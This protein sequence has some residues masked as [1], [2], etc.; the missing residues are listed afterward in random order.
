MQTNLIFSSSKQRISAAVFLWQLTRSPLDALANLAR[1]QGDIARARIGKREIFLLNHPEFI[2]QALVKQSQ[3]FVKGLA[4]QRARLLLGE[5]LLTSEGEDHLAQRRA[6]QPAF[7]PKRIDAYLPLMNECAL[8]NLQ[9]WQS[10]QRLNVTDEMARLT[11]DIATQTLFGG[12][13]AGATERVR[14]A[15]TTLMHL[16]PLVTLPLP[17]SARAWFPNFK[18]AAADLNAVT[19]ALMS[20]PHMPQAKYALVNILRE[21]QGQFSE[22]QIR[23]HALTFLLAGHETTALLL[24]W[25]FDL[26]AH[27]LRVQSQIQAEVDRVLG[28]RLPMP[29]DIAKLTY[30]RAVVKE[31]LRMRPPAW[32]IGREAVNA[33]EIGGQ[34]IPSHATV[35]VSPWVMHHD[36]RFYADPNAFRPE[37]W[38]ALENSLPRY[39]FFPF[40]GGNRVCIGEKFAWTEAIA[41]LAIV[42]RRW[43]VLP[44]AAPA[45]P[46]PSATLRPKNGIAVFLEKRKI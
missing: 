20:N 17:D 13:P 28:D 45:I 43:Q 19:A 25:A 27:D 22:E 23:A 8:E 5:G 38:E 40:G 21:N 11:L 9:A 2:E 29:E 44:A 31:T 1:K 14:K 35:L 37:R 34:P 7:H 10:G 36:A 4:L 26:L 46:Q 30:T 42:F 24:A 32:A 16:F 33:C 3:N 41:V 6:L 15:L 39:A 12:I 18:R